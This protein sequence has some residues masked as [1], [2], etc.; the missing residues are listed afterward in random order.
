[1]TY[2][3]AISTMLLSGE[4][5]RLKHLCR[6]RPADFRFAPAEHLRWDPDRAFLL[7]RALSRLPGRARSLLWMW[8][9]AVMS[10][11]HGELAIGTERFPVA[12]LIGI[13]GIAA[14]ARRFWQR[15]QAASDRNSWLF[16]TI[17]CPE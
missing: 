16:R 12:R 17:S 8:D 5:S 6:H 13:E 15:R 7:L 11:D 2:T 3:A 14:P 10:V 4:I 9:N 1:M